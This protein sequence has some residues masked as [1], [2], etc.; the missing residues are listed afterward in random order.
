MKLTTIHP[1]H[2]EAD[3]IEDKGTEVT[4]R[5]KHRG[6]AQVLPVYTLVATTEYGKEVD[7]VIVN[8]SGKTGKISLQRIGDIC[9]P[10]IDRPLEG[11]ED[12]E[13]EEDS[14]PSTA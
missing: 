1:T 10:E 7:R 9:V 11:V 5:L 13:S 3:V 12:T 14:R 4:H 2:I 8:V 6:S